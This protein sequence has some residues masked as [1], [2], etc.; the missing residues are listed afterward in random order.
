MLASSE[1]PAVSIILPTYNR[2]KFLPQAFAS[3]R[4]QTFTDW[5]L[6]V[7][8]DGSTDNTWES[9]EELTQ[10]WP[11]PVRYHPQENRGAY[12]A[13]NTGLD[14][15][16]GEYVAFYDSDD[17]WLP[18]H[19]ADCVAGLEANPDVDWAYGA[20]RIIDLNTGHTL[21]PNTLYERG[22]PRPLMKLRTRRSG[23][24]R[25]IDDPKS[26]HVLIT[27]GLYCGLQ[28]SVIRGLVFCG[29]R[30]ET[31][32]RNEAEDVLVAI[33]VMAAGHRFGYF[34]NVHAIYSIHDHNSSAA[35][36]AQAIDKRLT[37]H[38]AMMAGLEDLT[39]TLR[40]PSAE[41]R[42]L[43]SSLAQLCFWKVGYALL[44]Q[45]GRWDEALRMFRR[46]MQA[47]PWAVKQWTTY[48]LCWLRARVRS[49]PRSLDT[50]TT[51]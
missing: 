34:D 17:V 43:R 50:T 5:E 21:A 14:L 27:S 47:N 30:F 12:G 4:S 9:V 44:W 11:Q 8:D 24:F 35:G 29:R 2:A 37:V 16:R 40:L 13:R 45:N 28:N 26:L 25:V 18:H 32:F 33:R 38:R 7:V 46:G 15:A 6:I 20:C 10:G 3:I 49:H 23:A 42:A 19:L 51:P 1:R 48:V 22:R 31:R 39:A 41:Y 36:T